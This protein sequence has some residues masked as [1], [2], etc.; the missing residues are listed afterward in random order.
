MS[1]DQMRQPL[2][3]AEGGI[4]AFRLAD[5]IARLKSGAEWQN[6][7]RHAVSLVKD[8]ALNVLL[9]ALKKGARLHPHRVK[10]PIV[11]Q[12]LSG[13]IRASAGRR[14]APARALP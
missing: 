7:D 14:L 5:E 10:G 1:A 9:M 4:V 13:Q 11:V 6:G 2:R 12:L 3:P 8:D